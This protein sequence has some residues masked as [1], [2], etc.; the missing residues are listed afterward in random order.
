MVTMPRE[1][2]AKEFNALMRVFRHYDIHK[3]IVGAETG[4]GGYKHWQIRMEWRL[5]FKILKI[6]FPRGHIEKANNS[7]K[8]WQYEAKEGFY[9]KSW[10]RRENI[11]QRFGKWRYSQERICEYLEATN[12]REVVVWYDERGGCGKSWFT[13]S[14]WEKGMA[15]FTV[16]DSSVKTL[17]Q[18][19]ASEYLKNG[20]RPIVCIDI[21]RAAKWTTELYEAIERIKDGLIKD[22]RYSSASVNISGVKV[23]ICTNSRPKLDKLSF[24]RWKIVTQDELEIEARFAGRVP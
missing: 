18:D 21:P 24:D 1:N 4:N 23:L 11:Q 2:T 19:I 8:A 13:R 10:D 15:Y 14:L 5:D 3:W 20:W 6:L 16:A 17:V 7:E 12:D 22:P 9:W